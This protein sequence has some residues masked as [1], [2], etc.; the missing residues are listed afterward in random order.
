MSVLQS[1]GTMN[2]VTF[3]DVLYAPDMFVSIISHSRIRDKGLYYHGWDEKVYWKSDDHKIVYTPEID[4]IPNSLQASSD[5]EVAQA[6]AFVSAH[7]P[8]PNS[9]VLPTRKVSLAELH[10]LFGHT[11]VRTLKQLVLSTT[12][13][14][15][16]N[17]EPYSC[18]TCL[19]GNSYKQI[20]CQQPQRATQPFQRV[21]FDIFGPVQPTGDDKERY[22]IIY[23]EDSSMVKFAG[24]VA[25]N[26]NCDTRANKHPALLNITPVGWQ[27][28]THKSLRA[29][30]FCQP[31]N[32]AESPQ[33]TPIVSRNQHI[34]QCDHDNDGN[35]QSLYLAPWLLLYQN[36]LGYFQL[37]F[38]H[39]A[40]Q[41]FLVLV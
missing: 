20:S 33:D 2:S 9:A 40:V 13:L 24:G 21:H 6:F 10:E 3:S 30:D 26:A 22:W 19:L 25:I 35:I 7:S 23:T 36:E 37:Q 14:E 5:I 32:V 39:I 12:G 17:K 29:H 28:R 27:S 38:V 41:P 15:I 4:G 16:T 34:S 31:R 8:R 1:D 18:E 11:D